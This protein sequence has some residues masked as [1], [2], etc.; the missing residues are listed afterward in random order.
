MTETHP[1]TD[2]NRLNNVLSQAVLDKDCLDELLEELGCTRWSRSRGGR[3]RF[4]CPVHEGVGH[5]MQINTSGYAMPIRWC[6]FSQQCHVKWKPSLLGLVRGTLSTREDRK[7]PMKEVVD[8]IQRF[9]GDLPDYQPEPPRP[10]PTP[11][12]LNLTREQVRERLTIPSPYFVDRGFPPEVLDAFDVGYSPVLGREV[13]PLYDDTGEVCIGFEARSNKP[14]CGDCKKYHMP[15][16]ECRYGQSKWRGL[17]GFLKDQYLYNYARAVDTE[18][19]FVFLVEGSPDVFRLAEAGY[20]GVA[21]LG[22]DATEKQLRKLAALGKEVWIAFDNDDAGL[23]ARERFWDKKLRSGIRFSTE[24]F[25][26]PNPYKDLGEM[27]PAEIKR[28]VE[29]HIEAMKNRI[30]F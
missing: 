2:W 14:L 24:S 9:V 16:T 7:V 22:S 20:I 25:T 5:H 17:P 29:S 11:K 13:V 19:P 26:V 30:P 3:R 4:P 8:F 6:C 21:I 27:P 18:A 15:G 10:K 23:A 12:L 28:A 1:K